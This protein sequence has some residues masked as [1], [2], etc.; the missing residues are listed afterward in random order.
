M[1][2]L[3]TLGW[4]TRRS[5]KNAELR[6]ELRFHLE[7][8]EDDLREH[9]APGDEARRTARRGLGN[10]A[11]VEEDTRA[12]WGWGGLEQFGRDVKYGLRQ[13]RRHGAL[14]AIAIATLALGIGGVAAM[15]SAVETVLLR[16]LPYADADRLVMI[17][18]DMA[19]TDVTTKHNATP[20]EW[21]EWRRRNTVF[22][23]LATSQPTDGVLS[24]DG[25]PE[26]VPA[27]KVS[28]TF[29]S[30][31]GTSP[32]IG[33]AFTEAEDLE[34]VRVAVISHGLWQR[35]FGGSPDI[36][37]RTIAIN[38]EP[39]QVIG[40]MPPGFYFLP[41]RDIDLWMPASFP[42]WMRTNFSWHNAQ[43]V[44]RLAPGVT[45][46]QAQQSMSALSLE[47]TAKDERGP[48]SV[49]IVPL[50][51]EIAGRTRT[52]LILLLCASAAV[53]LIACVNLA[54]LLLSRGAT[55]GQEVA[56]RTALGASRAR[57]VAQ[58]L[59]ESLVLA[60]CGTLAGLLL[61]L[62]VM[63]FLERLIPEAMSPAR[64]ALNWRVLAFAA[65]AGGAAVLAFGLAPAL[66]ASRRPPQLGLRDG[67]RAIGPRSHWLRYSLIVVETALAVVLLTCGGLLLQT[68]QH[69]RQTD[70]GFQSERLLTFETPLFRY[71]DFD[72]RVAFVE[73]E[74]EKVRTIPG[75][76]GAAA[77]NLIP[78]T[79][80]ASATF[81]QLEGQPQHSVPTQV[82]LVRNVTRDY[83]TTVGAR[84]VEGRFFETTDRR[85]SMPV[86]IINEPMAR[87]HFGD[88]SALGHRFKF[89]E[90]GDE[91]YLYTIVGVVRQIPETGVLDDAKPV[92][93]R[94]FEQCDQIGDTKAALVVR[95]AVEP[96][97]IVPAVRQA[98]WS[99]DS[100]QPLARIQT[101]E[102]IIERQLS[103]PSQ[104]SALL[105][106]FA[107]LALLLASLG[108][109]GV[110]SHAVAQRTNEI[111]VRMALGATSGRILLFFGS[112][113]LMLTLAGLSIGLGLAAIA[114]R[115]MT[116]LLYGF[117]PDY[118][119]TAGVVS[120]VLVT[121]AALACL[122]P[123]RRAAHINPVAALRS[124]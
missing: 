96:A 108:I 71:K 30:V 36:V 20:A 40:V 94:V 102:D 27:R 88:Q 117:G 18:L 84:M 58:L 100:N 103:T 70:I 90:L 98:I 76:V 78:F 59:T 104:S 3:R 48:H 93:Y 28:W 112:R 116:T 35:R 85:A 83:F 111:G 44:A 113:G 42:P 15:F 8:D 75:V 101:M 1:S 106:A 47:L 53:L 124:D 95:T 89:G 69:L 17:W 29:W 74:V 54:N 24:G 66:G 34:N 114:A 4:L 46:E 64:L 23:D 61:A 45:L 43:V 25:G 32:M 60:A 92:V 56:V 33:R 65:C 122:V 52:A 110:L 16:P 14:S 72:R 11:R 68:F 5:A 105:G 21:L 82:A 118:A 13:I 12:A 63:R 41:A 37:G 39:Y 77:I 57:L 49:T 7:Q 79:N 115:W 31:L 22:S 73:A 10:L 51:D 19:K 9:G 97:S 87:R 91:G 67:R 99:L 80:F 107:V 62:P 86:A 109:Y 6:D 2:F 119:A 81:Y 123:A 120:A 38:D 26:Q 55:R 50:R 121:V